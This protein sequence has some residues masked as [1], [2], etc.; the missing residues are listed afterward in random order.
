MDKELNCHFFMGD[1]VETPIKKMDCSSLKGYQKELKN[2]YLFK[3]FYWQKGAFNLLFKSYKHY[4]LTGEL[5]CLSTWFILLFARLMNKKTYL[6]THGWYGRERGIK[7]TLK[8]CF[9]KLGSHVLLYGEYAKNLMIKEGFNPNKLHCIANSLDYNKQCIIRHKLSNTN[10]Y[11]NYFKNENPVIIYV[12]R[13]QKVKRIDLLIDAIAK[14]RDEDILVNL[15]LVGE[16]VEKESFYKQIENLS[17]TK[18]VWLY[19]AC[20]EESKLGE[21]FYNATICVSPGN[22]GLTAIHAFSYGCPII[23]HNCFEKQM[24]EF[25]VIQP[26]IN[27]LFFE[28]NDTLSLTQTIRYWIENMDKDKDGIRYSCYKIIDNKFNPNYQIKTLKELIN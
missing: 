18:Q 21:L 15:V 25:E 8:K 24:P 7:K 16:N 12:G 27:G 3:H 11:I 19:G 28:E 1:K 14:L 2:Y 23:T 13:I 22:V 4:I 20:Y 26:G 5:Y 9:F 6:W 10:I 17:L